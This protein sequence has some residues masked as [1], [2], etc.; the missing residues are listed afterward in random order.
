MVMAS[1]KLTAGEAAGPAAGVGGPTTPVPSPSAGDAV[2]SSRGESPRQPRLCRRLQSE[3]APAPVGRG[4]TARPGPSERREG[5]A[6]ESWRRQMPRGAIAD[7]R[8][9]YRGAACRRAAR[10]LRHAPRRGE[11]PARLRAGVV[12]TLDDLVKRYPSDPRVP[13]FLVTTAQHRRIKLPAR[14]RDLRARAGE[15]SG[16]RLSRVTGRRRGAQRS[17]SRSMRRA[18]GAGSPERPMDARARMV[19][20][21]I[22]GARRARC[23]RARRDRPRAARAVHPR[24]AT[25]ERLPGSPRPHRLRPDDLAALHRRLHDRGAEG[26]S[27]HIASWRSAPAAATRPRCSRS[28]RARSIPLS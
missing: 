11:S 3:L 16:R 28:W 6:R 10:R 12:S 19:A 17:C 20:D 13:N 14:P 7:M 8:K 2:A 9:N 27:R 24:R 15:K 26:S 4:P 21:Q 22:R 23:A 25:V 18:D 1:R 5:G